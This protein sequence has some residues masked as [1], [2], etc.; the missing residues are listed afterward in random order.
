MPAVCLK[1]ASVL[2][3]LKLAYRAFT[4][5]QFG[6]CKENLTQILDTVPFLLAASRSEANDL[7]ELI[8]VCREYLTAI[9]VKDE[10]TT[11]ADDT[12]RTLELGAYFTHCNLQPSH[13]LLAL[14]TAMATAFKNKVIIFFNAM[15]VF[16]DSIVYRTSSTQLHS[17][18]VYWSYPISIQSAMQIRE[19]KH[20]R[21]CRRVRRKVETMLRSIMTR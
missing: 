11:C 18:V 16:C 1:V 10:M 9:R 5:G 14:K 3:T 7:K 6:E 21:F 12:T 8:D 4:S 19:V 20:R 2:E 15:N 13:L 17:L